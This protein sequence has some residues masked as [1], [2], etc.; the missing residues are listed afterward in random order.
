M[1]LSHFA[2]LCPLLLPQKDSTFLAVF[3]FHSPLRFPTSSWCQEPLWVGVGE[4]LG[5]RQPLTGFLNWVKPQK[6]LHPPP[7]VM[8][9]VLQL[10]VLQCCES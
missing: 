4:T 5:I 8:V 7:Y 6:L 10:K 1:P 9:Q 3:D 2:P